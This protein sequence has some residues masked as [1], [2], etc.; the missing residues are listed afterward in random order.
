MSTKKIV[1]SGLISG[2]VAFVVGSLLYMNPLVSGIYSKYSDYPC[3]KP[4]DMFG[5]LGNWMLLMLIGGLFSTVFLAVL[6]S[7]TEKG[8][9]IQSTWKKGLFFGFLLWLVSKL[10]TSYYT[11][12]MYT[13]PNVLNVIETINGLIGGIV[14]GVVLAFLY[15]RIK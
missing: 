4:M 1:I 9:G 10:P 2:L 7:Y 15:E 5:G 14:A 12:L 6:Y 13:Y 11:W 3:S 8:I